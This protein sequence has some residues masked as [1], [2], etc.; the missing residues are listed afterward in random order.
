[1]LVALLVTVGVATAATLLV[2][3]VGLVRRLQALAVS[4]EHLNDEL[5]PLVEEIGKES[6]R[7]RD[8]L[9]RQRTQVERSAGGRSAGTR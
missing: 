5:Q 3:V 4:V 6:E 9:E 2:V 7:A 8:H 1:V